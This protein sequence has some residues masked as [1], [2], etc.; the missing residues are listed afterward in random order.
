MAHTDYTPTC[1]QAITG[2]STTVL[3][4]NFVLAAV[5]GM[6]ADPVSP[7]I[8]RGSSRNGSLGAAYS[9]TP[10]GVN[11]WSGH[12]QTE[13]AGAGNPIWMTLE[14]VKSG[15]QVCFLLGTA[16]GPVSS[17]AVIFALNK[18]ESGGAWRG[19]GTGTA[20]RPTDVTSSPIAA[21]EL[22]TAALGFS[23][24]SVSN[25]Y[26]NLWVR[27]DGRGFYAGLFRDTTPSL[28]ADGFLMGYFPL[29]E[30]FAADVNPYLSIVGNNN[31]FGNATLPFA[32]GSNV[33]CVGRLADGT[34]QEHRSMDLDT[35]TAWLDRLSPWQAAYPTYGIAWRAVTS[36]DVRYWMPDWYV[37]SGTV[38]ASSDFATR[39][40]K[41][42]FK[43]NPT[44][45]GAFGLIGPW[46]GATARGTDVPIYYFTNQ[47]VLPP[48][49][50]PPPTIIPV[51]SVLG[52]SSDEGAEELGVDI[53]VLD[54]LPPTFRLAKGRANLANAIAR[55]LA[56][57]SGWLA[58]A[59]AGDAEYGFDLRDKLN[60]SW[61]QQQLAAVAGRVEE[62]CRKD[63]RVLAAEVAVS[64]SLAASALTVDIALDTNAGPFKLVLNVSDVGSSLLLPE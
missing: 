3:R 31:S 58:Q 49:V 30:P 12:T 10:D 60:A 9:A 18:F 40:G 28:T 64:Y 26:F 20:T 38:P 35:T 56:T 51:T 42:H 27:K 15:H 61:T 14:S 52:P 8:C 1:G 7:Y 63:E 43:F 37:S 21:R 46:D 29:T 45:A 48:V 19:G 17:I 59:F 55:R 41:T 11:R 4:W 13:I 6:L 39:D 54:D 53:D 32:A 22:N 25:E 16:S 50:P 23:P 57:P 5:D 36:K 44:G 24:Q 47:P 33:S 2:A 34:L 62:E